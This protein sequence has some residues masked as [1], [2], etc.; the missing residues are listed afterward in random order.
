[1]EEGEKSQITNDDNKNVYW[2]SVF[3]FQ[4]FVWRIGD[5]VNLL[6]K[7]EI[8]IE[9]NFIYLENNC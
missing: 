8:S 2:C 4:T 1:M 3:S 7:L 9:Y 5:R 6:K